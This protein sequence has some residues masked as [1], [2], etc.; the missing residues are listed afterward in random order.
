MNMT[1]MLVPILGTIMLCWSTAAMAGWQDL[2]KSLTDTISKS[3]TSVTGASSATT[4]GLTDSEMI[5][6][7]KDALGVSIERTISQLGST[8]GFLGNS[9]VRIAVPE[10]LQ[11]V[12]GGLRKVGQGSLV[13]SFETSMNRAAEQAVPATADIFSE[14]IKEM[15]FA[16]AQAIVTGPDNA[17]TT[18]FEDT[19]RTS[20]F[21]RIKPIVQ[22]ETSRVG[23]TGYYK[24]MEDKASAM[25]PLISRG[26]STD[27]DSYVTDSALDGLFKVMAQYEKDIR[28]NPAARTT[29]MLQK[30]FGAA[31]K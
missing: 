7:L 23:V 16:D 11:M 10:K 9:M 8:N 3:K 5:T 22:A 17:A 1:R 24:A 31:G 19:T 12:A 27:L 13:D 29:D 18:Y 30:V 20:L 21:E 28:A 6:G 2:T 25:L 15:S 26:R 14:A 4:A